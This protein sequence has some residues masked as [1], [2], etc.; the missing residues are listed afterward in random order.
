MNALSDFYRNQLFVDWYNITHDEGHSQHLKRYRFLDLIITKFEIAASHKYSG[1][2]DGGA[3]V[4]A[5][6]KSFDLSKIRAKS[7]KILAKMASNVVWFEDLV[8]N[9]CRNTQTRKT[10]SFSGSHTKKKSSAS[11]LWEKMC[12]QKSHVWRNSDKS[13]SQPQKFAYS[14]TYAQIY[15]AKG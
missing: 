14:Y 1:V 2:R 13:R 4:Q 3:G 5:H 12:R 6:P 11:S 8:P 10:F 9:F 15:C 7:L